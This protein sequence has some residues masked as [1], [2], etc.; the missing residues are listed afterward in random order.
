MAF[1]VGSVFIYL[2]WL[3]GRDIKISA[4]CPVLLI[5]V[6]IIIY[7]LQPALALGADYVQ[8]LCNGVK[9][10]ITAVSV[11]LYSA[12]PFIYRRSLSTNIGKVVVTYLY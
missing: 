2:S 7:K 4:L 3:T 8:Q 6:F 12:I 11:I 10:S 9:A 5:I 1:C